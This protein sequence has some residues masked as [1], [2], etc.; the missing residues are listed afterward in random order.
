MAPPRHF[1]REIVPILESIGGPRYQDSR[2]TILD[3][4]HG[5]SLISNS[6]GDS[7]HGYTEDHPHKRERK[8]WKGRNAQVDRSS[9]SSGPPNVNNP[10]LR[11]RP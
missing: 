7:Y 1:V 3:R 11:P 9:D 5:L 6:I 2:E 8:G 4:H 10:K